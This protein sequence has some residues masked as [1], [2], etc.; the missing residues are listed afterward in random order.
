MDK[1]FDENTNNRKEN[2]LGRFINNYLYTIITEGNIPDIERKILKEKLT[3][4]FF[5]SEIK[6]N[7]MNYDTNGKEYQNTHH[8]NAKEYKMATIW[9]NHQQRA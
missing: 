8:Y 7:P 4:R 6:Y 9:I 1:E 5:D 3:H 2:R